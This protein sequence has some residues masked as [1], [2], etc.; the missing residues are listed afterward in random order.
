MTDATILTNQEVKQNLEM[1]PKWEYKDYMIS[2]EFKFKD[3]VEAFDFLN[4]LVP[5]F[6][7]LDHHP[8]IHIFYNK[9]KFELQTH[10]A[11]DKITDLDVKIAQEIEARYDTRG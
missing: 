9:I 2:K 3:F 6:E 10:S 11:G 7:S 4:K 8:D 1:L 5:Y